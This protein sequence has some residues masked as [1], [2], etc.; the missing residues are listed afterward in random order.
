MTQAQGQVQGQ[1]EAKQERSARRRLWTIVATILSVALGGYLLYRTLSGYSLAQLVDA[2]KALPLGRLAAAGGFAAASYLCLTG[3]DWLA[4]RAAGKPLPYPRVALAAFISLGLGHSIGF[5]GLSSGAIR[6]RFY[7]RWGLGTADVAKAVLFCGVTVAV[8]LMALGAVAVLVH[9]DLAREVTGLGKGAV[10]AAGLACAGGVAVYLGLAAWWRKPVT[11][12]RWSIEMPPL[13]LAAAQVGLGAVN[14][15]LVSACLHQ[16]LSAVSEVGYLA[17]A[18]VFVIANA[19]VLITHVPGGVGV[20]ESVVV[21][22]LPKTD[23]IGPLIA[24]RFLYF[25]V[26]LALGLVAFAATE[27]VFRWRDAEG[28]AAPTPRSRTA[29]PGRAARS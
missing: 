19:A 9:P 7:T 20:I 18:S 13:P 4:L 11:V 2:V 21:H 28:S 1:D 3:I 15:A 8:G 26:P 10:L 6:Y 23:V 22:L 14:F 5:A 24:F 17:V 16:V 12:R 25:L 29:A 27:A